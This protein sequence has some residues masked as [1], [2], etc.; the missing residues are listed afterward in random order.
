M[1]KNE[2]GNFSKKH[3]ERLHHHV[4]VEAIQLLGN[5]ELVQRLKK[6]SFRAGVVIPKSQI[7]V[8]CTIHTIRDR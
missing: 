7:T 4:N 1:I 5:S 8:K 2:T 6:K 3:E